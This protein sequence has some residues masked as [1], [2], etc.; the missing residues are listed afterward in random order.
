MKLEDKIIK[1]L[2]DAHKTLAVAE[3]MSRGYLVGKLISGYGAS[4]VVKGGVVAYTLDIKERVL[5]VPLEH[6]IRTNGVDQETADIM[7]KN[8]A[9]LM[10][11]DYGL[12]ITGIAEPY[13]ERPSQAYVSV[14]VKAAEQSYS[15]HKILGD[16]FNGQSIRNLAIDE[17]LQFFYENL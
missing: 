13:D 1:H 16:Q 9:E 6:T 11:A 4:I 15:K 2:T 8:V 14:F 7:A 10:N 5:S 17:A 3:S 12:A